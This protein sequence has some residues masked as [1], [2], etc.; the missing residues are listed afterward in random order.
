MSDTGSA[1]ADGMASALM[2][3]PP[4]SWLAPGTPGSA[5]ESSLASNALAAHSEA[6]HSDRAAPASEV[7]GGADFADTA[8]IAGLKSRR[9]LVLPS[10]WE[11]VAST[12]GIA[13]RAYRGSIASRSA[14]SRSRS[15]TSLYL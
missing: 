5:V 6:E 9:E 4:A 14:A 7:H 12:P 10:R 2:L 15:P 1:T 8:F 13:P 3:Q 11:P